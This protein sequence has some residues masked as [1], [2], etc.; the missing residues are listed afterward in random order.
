MSKEDYSLDDVI[1]GLTVTPAP[2][3]FRVEHHENDDK[4]AGIYK[5][6]KLVL[7]KDQTDAIT[8]WVD[9]VMRTRMNHILPGIG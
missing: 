8:V 2:T 5:N 6:G 4:P 7:T 1:E 3:G 9:I